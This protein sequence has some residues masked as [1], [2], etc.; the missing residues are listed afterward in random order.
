MLTLSEDNE[1]A[2]EKLKSVDTGIMNILSMNISGEASLNPRDLLIRI[3]AAGKLVCF[4]EMWF[5][6]LIFILFMVSSS[7][8]HPLYG[9]LLLSSSSLRF[10]PLIFILFT[11][12]PLI[13]ILFTVS[14]SYHHLLYGFLLLSSSSLR[15]P[16]LIFISYLGCFIG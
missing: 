7:Y 12:P 1:H 14:S 8:L 4:F 11:F 10:A 2:V 6:P 9:F 5:P 13:F 3:L 15:F 16:P